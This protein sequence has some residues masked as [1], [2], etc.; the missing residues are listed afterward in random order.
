LSG[1]SEF[2][3]N[4]ATMAKVHSKSVFKDGVGFLSANDL[5]KLIEKGLPGII[6]EVTAM[7]DSYFRTGLLMVLNTAREVCLRYIEHA[8]QAGND[9]VKEN[10]SAIIERAPET[11]AEALQLILIIELLSHDKHYELNQLDVVLG[12]IY[13]NELQNGSL[14]EDT[15]MHQIHEFYKMIHENGELGV[16]R[17]ILGGKNRRNPE[18]ADL[19]IS[20]AL[21][22]EQLHKK[23]IPQ[24]TLRLYNGMNPDLL[25][26]AYETINETYTFPTLF[27]DESIIG[28]FAKAYGVSEDFANQ[29]YYP[30][31]CGEM[32]IHPFSPAILIAGWGV[33][34]TVNAGIRNYF[35]VFKETP[36]SFDDLYTYVLDALKTEITAKAHYHRLVVDTQNENCSFLL[37][38]LLINDCI[39]TGKPLLNGGARFN[40][41]VVMGHGYTNASDSLYAIKKLV[42]IEKKYSLAQI[43]EAL[44]ADFKGYNNIKKAL[45]D[46]P[47]YGNDDAD[48]DELTSKLWSD[49]TRLTDAAGKKYGFDFFTVSSVNPGGYGEGYVMGATAD[50]RHKGMPYAIGNAPTA[51]MDKNGLTALMNSVLKTDPANGG[52]MTNFKISREFFTGEREKFEALFDTY[53]NGGGLQANITILSKGDLEAA[54]K[55]PEK[56]PHLL[57]RLGGWTARFIDLEPFIQKEIIKRTLY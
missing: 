48:V 32:I 51:G 4:E 28:G 18:N 54:V 44:D 45:I 29:H 24:V 56:Y 23:V 1:L 55:E 33:P 9:F 35:T 43:L 17:L 2:W 26:L 16:C 37:A 11:L 31:G 38:S 40:G 13:A 25:K 49:I 6:N 46:V 52:T 15:A 53:W 5:E 10:V 50:G 30:C 47:K 12:D 19:F 8:E 14:T 57:V 22:A 39:E 34:K 27:N 20:A 36:G 21:K 42:F 41:A 3:Q 7:P